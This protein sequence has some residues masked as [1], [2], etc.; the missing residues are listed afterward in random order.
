MTNK[1]LQG[2]MFP[3]SKT[4]EKQPD[5]RGSALI[6]GV[7]YVIAGWKKVSKAGNAYLSLAFQKKEDLPKAK[8]HVHTPKQVVNQVSTAFGSDEIVSE[9]E[10]EFDEVLPF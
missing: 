4:N 7:E 9:T 8:T 10:A 6:G 5:L 2:V 3:N 1:E